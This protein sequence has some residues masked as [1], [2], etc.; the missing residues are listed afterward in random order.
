M[1]LL[2]VRRLAEH[3]HEYFHLL[4]ELVQ[5]IE[6]GDA[7]KGRKTCSVGMAT[8][9]QPLLINNKGVIGG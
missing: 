2:Q 8:H 7:D 3:R 5:F 1:Y 9:P 4:R 6:M